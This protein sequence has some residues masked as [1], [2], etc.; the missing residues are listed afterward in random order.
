MSSVSPI[1]LTESEII[2]RLREASAQLQ[3]IDQEAEGALDLRRIIERLQE[4]ILILQLRRWLPVWKRIGRGIFPALFYY[5]SNCQNLARSKES[6]M[7]HP[8]LTEKERLALKTL[9]PRGRHSEVCIAVGATSGWHAS[10]LIKRLLELK[11]VER[12]HYP[13]GMVKRGHYQRVVRASRTDHWL[14]LMLIT[15]KGRA[16]CPP[17]LLPLR[18]LRRAVAQLSER[19]FCLELPCAPAQV[20]KHSSNTDLGANN[21]KSFHQFSAWR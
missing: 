6:K 20:A 11:L 17:F 5:L 1:W 2:I 15:Q 12:V 7:K 3:L 10:E 13:T 19:S 21:E 14:A 4:A 8:Q 9:T 18:L 16:S